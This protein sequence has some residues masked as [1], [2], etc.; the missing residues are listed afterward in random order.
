[1]AALLYDLG[2]ALAVIAVAGIVAAVAR[3]SVVPAY[4]L[5]GVLVGPFAPEIGGYS[6]SLIEADTTIY[7]VLNLLG[8][9]GIV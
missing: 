8:T 5:I 6:L 9:L 7:E 4:L 3:Q 2:L 1:M